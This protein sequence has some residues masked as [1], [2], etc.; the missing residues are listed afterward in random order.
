LRAYPTAFAASELILTAEAQRGKAASFQRSA[1]KRPAARSTIGQLDRRHKNLCVAQRNE[2]LVGQGR[3]EIYV[4]AKPELTEVAEDAEAPDC[5]VISVSVAWG[6]GDV[7]AGPLRIS[8]TT[9]CCIIKLIR[10]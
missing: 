4:K 1:L 8:W 6:S 7:M 9:A 5:R 10:Q 3:R 2:E